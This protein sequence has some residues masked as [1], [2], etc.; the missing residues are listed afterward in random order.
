LTQDAAQDAPAVKPADPTESGPTDSPAS[1]KPE[2]EIIRSERSIYVPYQDLEAI[3]EK[4]GRGVFLPYR[5]FLDLWNQLNLKEQKDPEKP[6]TDG[7]V[8]SANYVATVE[9][10]ENRVLAIDAVLQV[11]SFKEKGW[12]VVPLSKSGLNI[13]EAET[14]DATIH[15]GKSGYELILP[16]KGKYEI[17]LKLYSKIDHSG[18]RNIAIID[19]PRAGVSKFEATL[20]EQGWNFEFNPTAAY[21]TDALADGQTKLAFFLREIEQLSLTWKKQGEETKLTPLLFVESD[22]TSSVV[23]GALQS[24]LV[25]N[26]RILRSGVGNFAISVPKGQEILNVE[27]ENIKEWNVTEMDDDQKLEVQLHTPAKKIYSL[28]LTLEEALG[29]LPTELPLPRVSTENAVRQRGTVNVLTSRE[30]E[31]ETVSSEG[32]SQQSLPSSAKNAKTLRPYGKFRYLSLPFD[33][34]LSVKKA[35]P[36]IEVQSW[37]RFSVDPDSSRFVTRFDYEVK[38]VGIFDVQLK[39]PDDFEGVEATGDPVDDFSEETDADGNKILTVTLKNRTEG[40][41]SIN[42]TGRRDR[43]NPAETETVPVFSPLKVSRHDGKVGLQIHTSLDPKTMDEG[44]LRQQD[45]SLLGS[46]IPGSGPLQIGFRYRG[47]AA[48]AT[49]GFTLKKTQISGEIFT[50]VEVREQIVRYQWTISYQ[51]L[52]AGVDTLVIAIPKSIA[53]NLRHDG[54]LIKEVDKNYTSPADAENP[55]VAAADEVLWAVVL[56]DKKMGNYQLTL[57]LDQ[58]VGAAATATENPD[59]KKDDSHAARTFPV[60]LP[61]IRLEQVQTETGQVAVVKDDN[62]EILDAKTTALESVDPKELRGG[63]ARPGVFLS[64]KYRQHPVALDLEVSR[65]EFLAVPQAVVTYAN[66]TSV[67]SNDGAITSEVIYWVK[68]N[69]K[70]FLSVTLPKGGTMVSDIYVNGQ[71]QQPMR[72]ANEDVVLIRLP[73]GGDQAHANFPLRFIY[74]LPSPNPGVQLGMFGSLALPAADLVDAEILQSQL[75]LYLPSDYLYKKFTSAMSLPPAERGWARFRNA[76]DWIIPTLGPQIPVNRARLW[77]DPPVL[78]VNKGGGFDLQV[79]TEGQMFTLHRLDAPATVKIS[80]RGKSFAFFWEALMGLLAFAGAIYLLW[81]TVPWRLAYLAVAGI[82]PLIIAG[83]VSPTSASFW[84]AIYLGTFLG[85][86]VW[87][88]RGIPGFLK[89]RWQGLSNCCSRI[90]AHRAEKKAARLSAQELKK[91]KQAE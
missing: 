39:I 59:E 76:F 25:L 58:P 46:N 6:P 30:L 79:P 52:Y 70:Q 68:N 84:T 32:L 91:S 33:L 89:R 83:A 12:A 74:E 72:R 71:P 90:R 48:P 17:S 82:L 75:R 81:H 16:H 42:V 73:V 40:K 36:L 78:P 44:D 41:F 19:L 10:K 54:T 77:S 61:E 29:S 51:I 2:P 87:L 20:P 50:L 63:L 18:G 34:T 13:A 53:E 31:V 60:S 49:V 28:K 14:G 38:G 22:L 57:T 62:L 24:D 56:R 7:I 85:A 67:V 15:L 88:L 26:Y 45:V 35:K 1:G 86:M 4:E 43:K 64:Y 8:A 9:G 11:E 23:P 65:N 37:T 80:Y 27:G 66:L 21:S 3:F 5:E 55:P 69:A 47:Q